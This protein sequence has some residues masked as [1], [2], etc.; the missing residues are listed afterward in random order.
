[1]NNNL[2]QEKKF[3]ITVDRYV[4]Y[5]HY[6]EQLLAQDIHNNGLGYLVRSLYFDTLQDRDYY[7][8]LNG[9]EIRR[10]IR[11]RIYDTEGDVALLEVKQKQGAQ[12]L[13]RSLKIAKEDAI[14][15][16]KG[17]YTCLLKYKEPFAAECFATMNT[18]GYR[19]KSIVQYYRKAFVA[20]E[21][22][23]RLTF[24]YSILATEN[25]FDLFS[26]KL[27]LYP[28]LDSYHVILEVKYKDFLLSY[29]KEI[30]NQC[31]QSEISISKYCL[32]RSIGLHYRL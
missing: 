22:N 24:D 9:I 11:L 15:L 19:P 30:I 10:K 5:A 13:K 18:L 1:M 16:T 28:I 21:N 6:F 23:T 8:K 4:K 29:I 12:Q 32:S 3:L 17:E 2:R 7:E 20:R 26:E 27:S 31:D 25:C 14:R